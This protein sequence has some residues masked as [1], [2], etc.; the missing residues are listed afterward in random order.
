MLLAYT[1]QCG[2]VMPLGTCLWEH[3]ARRPSAA[4]CMQLELIRSRFTIASTAAI[5]QVTPLHI[6]GMSTGIPSPARDAREARNVHRPPSG[7]GAVE[8]SDE[9]DDEDDGDPYLLPITHEVSLQCASA[10]ALASA[11]KSAY[12]GYATFVK[13]KRTHC[14]SLLVLPLGP[15]SESR[16][17]LFTFVHLAARNARQ[18][19][20]TAI[21]AD[22]ARA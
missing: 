4:Y 17:H 16:S 1:V 22:R 10:L 7:A 11:I 15:C 13:P 12:C 2:L 14:A 20:R 9:D 21:V 19:L 8:A 6:C 5:S 18:K 3:A